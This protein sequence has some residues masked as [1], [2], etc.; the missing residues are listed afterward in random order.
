[1]SYEGS[2]SRKSY[3]L[4]KL[5]RLLEK[6]IRRLLYTE[7]RA[8]ILRL[9][10]RE[11]FRPSSVAIIGASR[12]PGK[13][14][15][16]LLKNILESGYRGPIYPI[17]PNAEEILGIK[18]YPSVLDVDGE[19]ELA[20]VAIP[21]G[22]VPA[23]AEECGRKG[24]KAMIVISAGFRESGREGYALERRL[25]EIGSIYG[26]RI[27]G[28]NCLGLIDTWT[29]INL[30]FASGMPK[31]GEIGF[32]SQSGALGTAI[33]DWMI[34]HGIGFSSFISLGNKADLDEVDFIEALGEDESVKAILLYIESIERG[35]RF[36][37]VSRKVSK[38]KPIV[39]LKGGTSTAGAKAA[40]S[41]T[42]ALV[43]N[44][45]SYKAAFRKAGIILSDSLED[46]FNYAI[47]FTWQP[48]PKG[49]KVA[50]VT[51]AGGPGIIATDLCEKLGIELAELNHETVNRLA[52]SLPP[53]ASIVNPIDILGDARADRYR[54]AIDG[55]LED[56]NVDA[57]LVI[58]SPQ[59]MTEV[60]A[61]AEALVEA[62]GKRGDKPILSVFMGGGL[63]EEAS[64]YLKENR[65]PCFEFPED[66]VKALSTLIEYSRFLRRTDHPIRRLEDADP[67]SVR[68]TL[69]GVRG[70]GR[71]NLL[72]QEAFRVLEAYGIRTPKSEVATSA[73]EAVMYAEKIGYPVALKI[74]SPDIMHK[75]DIGGVALNLGS[76]EEV[77]YT[78][79]DIM[80][81]ASKLMPQARLTG[82]MVQKMVPKGREM[83]VGMTRDRQFGPLIMFGLGGIYVNFLR[84]VSFSLAPLTYEEATWMIEE[85]KASILLKGIRGE[86]PSDIEALKD[87]I[88]RVSQLALDFPEILEMDINPVIVYE[89]GKGCIS[90]DVKI[91]LGEVERG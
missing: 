24:V 54:I 4:I 9:R 32:I 55:A 77:R 76:E 64:R 18:C 69:G 35:K 88:L 25:I 74:V 66:G 44:F 47:S 36:M 34:K 5:G 48:I 11:F 85:T 23:V 84:D 7:L 58:L 14:G 46:L 53:A 43:G 49:E 2:V 59:A 38:R 30:T 86:P 83:I 8:G 12:S 89:D 40:G 33:L 57:L 75:T 45:T 21:A 16:V 72:P 17:N 79:E 56:P 3:P 27:L 1:M 50:I 10:L 52:R 63:V 28:P 87:V 31:R 73:D 39:A 29:P 80:A 20:V 15:Y 71:I 60:R 65:I 68:E 90:L 19:V 51:N 22:L 62:H 41:H 37:E 26:M 81:K 13:L 61:T 82:V 70:D 42:G 67:N 6:L 78:F 91:T